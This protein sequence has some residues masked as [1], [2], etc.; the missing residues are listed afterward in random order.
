MSKTKVS[1]D[2]DIF[3]PRSKSPRFDYTSERLAKLVR[4]ASTA[5]PKSAR[6]SLIGKN[7]LDFEI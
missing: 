2:F 4:S 5:I 3:N 7:K 1:K 6:N